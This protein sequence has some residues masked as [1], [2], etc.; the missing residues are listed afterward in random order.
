MKKITL[1][2]LSVILSICLTMVMAVPAFAQT[3]RRESSYNSAGFVATLSCNSE[4]YS[5]NIG[6]NSSYVL[7][8]RSIGYYTVSVKDKTENGSST[9][10]TP[11]STGYRISAE[12]TE[13]VSDGWGVWDI[14]NANP[15]AT[16]RMVSATCD[17]YVNRVRQFSFE[18]YA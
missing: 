2:L 9:I 14:A 17:F 12:K 10:T 13:Y 3:V 1:R 4:S 18:A 8:T 5:C 11:Y 16:V 15:G 7:K 6:S